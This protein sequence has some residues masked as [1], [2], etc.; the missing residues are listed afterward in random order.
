MCVRKEGNHPA[1]PLPDGA[2]WTTLCLVVS[3]LYISLFVALFALPD[4]RR[5]TEIQF[6]LS[7]ALCQATA[8]GISLFL[9]IVPLFV[10]ARRVKRLEM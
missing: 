1:P 7:D 5:V 9:L 3:F 2:L 4:L 8:I 10:A 6:L